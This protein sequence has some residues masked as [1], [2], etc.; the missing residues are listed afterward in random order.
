M[1]HEI[2]ITKKDLSIVDATPG[3]RAFMQEGALKTNRNLF[4]HVPVLQT[5][6]SPEALREGGVFEGIMLGTSNYAVQVIPAGK[7]ITFLFRLDH[8]SSPNPAVLSEISELRERTELL[9]TIIEEAPIGLILCNEDGTI[10]YMNKKQEENSRKKRQQLIDHD[11]RD[12]Y[13]KTFE[14][15]QITEF[16]DRV[17]NSSAPHK[18]LI[19][20]HYYP[21][22][23]KRDIVIKFLAS[24]LKVHKKIAIFVEIEDELYREKRKAEKAGE[25]LRMSQ[26]Y[27]AQLL[28]SSPNM[29]ISVDEKRRVVSFNK[30]AER[31]LGFRASEVYNSPVDRF[32]PKEEL[33]KLDLAVSSQV[34]WYGTIH[35]YRSDRSSFPIELYSTKVKDER[36]GKDIATL[37]LA[38]DIE[39]RNKLRKNL[40]QS[41]K[42]NFIG[43]LV[44]GLAHQIN[45]PLVGV[46]NIADVLL[47]K[48]DV[49][50]EK[51]SYVRMIREAGESCKDV[52]SRLLR[53]SRRQEGIPQADIDI[54]NVLDAGIEML[55]KHPK[56]KGV[57]VERSYH[58]V[59][60]IRGDQVLLQQAFMNM[61]INSAQALDGSGVIRVRCGPDHTRGSQVVVAIADTGCG[62]PEEDIPRV[63]E[64]F[65]STKEADDGTGIGLSLTY[66]IIQDHGG[67]I[68]VESAVGKGTTFTT[69]L[70]VTS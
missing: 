10:L 18:A 35:I 48:I 30:T 47:Q 52:I 5:I 3:C 34:L 16:F 24:R 19:L 7:H 29:V 56:L 44:S 40:I 8:G 60:V 36:T 64:P 1:Q 39:E 66:W 11:I 38:V 15:P 63:F 31:L 20:D 65:F 53:F 45:N 9:E 43:E 54:R 37:L 13:R 33:P 27:M 51:Y 25:E 59:P 57:K 55:M 49:D 28:D 26:S 69:Y 14:Y 50:D 67:R 42:M 58:D 6:L 21:Q 12:I 22:F 4:V 61:L 62:I 17:M 2:I 23:Y 68:S 32:F 70:P 46:I 41:Q